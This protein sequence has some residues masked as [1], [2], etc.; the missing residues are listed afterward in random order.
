[1]TGS[2]TP[3]SS[4]R[5]GRRRTAIV[6]AAWAVAG[7][8]LFNANAAFAAEPDP[9]CAT[10]QDFITDEK[11]QQA[12]DL[13]DA[14][15]A[16]ARAQLE[17]GVGAPPAEGQPRPQEGIDL[18]AQ[19]SVCPDEYGEALMAVATTKA[20]KVGWDAVGKTW[21][22]FIKHRIEPLLGPGLAALA[23]VAA[24]FV[25]ARL[26]VVV[27]PGRP[28]DRVNSRILWG[29]LLVGIA[30]M[31]IA[32][33]S[34]AAVAYGTLSVYSFLPIMLIAATGAFMVAT[35]IGGRPRLT[36]EAVKEDGSSD[37]SAAAE[38]A[39]YLGELTDKPSGIELP[40]TDLSGLK[41]SISAELPTGKF[42]SS[43]ISA[44]QTLFGVVPWRVTIAMTDLLRTSVL[45]RRNG[46]T[47]VAK[48]IDLN[49]YYP[50]GVA[51][52]FVAVPSVPIDTTA[53][54]AAAPPI[55]ADFGGT[56]ETPSALP[57][58]PKTVDRGDRRVRFA[59]RL[60]A[61]EFIAAMAKTSHGFEGLYRA[62]NGT[63]IGLYN[64][65]KNE[66]TH[67]TTTAV[68]LLAQ[69]LAADPQNYLA[70]HSLEAMSYRQSTTTA[71]LSRYAAW[72][73][74]RITA[75]GP[76]SA[77]TMEA[78]RLRLRML[79]IHTIATRNLLA[80]AAAADPVES[81]S[82]Q[83][84]EGIGSAVAAISLLAVE[85]SIGPDLTT[86][87]MNIAIALRVLSSGVPS[88]QAIED[89]T[90]TSQAWLDAAITSS[91]PKVAYSLLCAWARTIATTYP[92]TSTGT[93]PADPLKR[94]K[95]RIA[96]T[97]PG[98]PAWA[99]LDPELKAY[100]DQPWF[101]DE[102]TYAN[103]TYPPL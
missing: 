83:R 81:Y 70:E 24:L 73:Q 79:Y 52:P 2:G 26:L 75:D 45:I 47:V 77:A 53:V 103:E 27:F 69:A 23:I 9:V 72:L 71:G 7:S 11:P 84:V 68:A 10:A 51:P 14:V 87:R 15:R 28:R 96:L 101:T 65:G 32:A 50:L 95:L 39:A 91:E 89:A 33:S 60:A 29:N 35:F 13:I 49:L 40:S 31:V 80:A 102:V 20:P 56:V 78:R 37:A 48:V 44:L 66:F 4:Q 38:V 3:S 98:T 74:D 62:T 99:P 67:D 90:T 97:S 21:D 19:A 85:K 94:W 76:H 17:A 93:L 25:L 86:L 92:G 54:I 6:L 8:A 1:V 57:L 100:R 46:R 34:A 22:D 12:I 61:A 64:I 41:D 82:A 63:S 5:A 36:I 16:D 43:V 59:R 55:A 58:V 42:L 18:L 88:T 30:L